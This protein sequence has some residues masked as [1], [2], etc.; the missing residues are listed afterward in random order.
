MKIAIVSHIEFTQTSSGSVAIQITCKFTQ[1]NAKYLINYTY[2]VTNMFEDR[3]IHETQA[4]L[5]TRTKYI[6]NI[7]KFIHRNNNSQ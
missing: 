1:N 3:H 5:H 2:S 4:H 7:D 6:H